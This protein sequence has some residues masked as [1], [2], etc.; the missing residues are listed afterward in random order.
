MI[1]VY[2]T[3]IGTAR[4]NGNECRI[5]TQVTALPTFIRQREYKAQRDG[6]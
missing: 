5:V 3:T 4:S 1:A 6:V 2:T